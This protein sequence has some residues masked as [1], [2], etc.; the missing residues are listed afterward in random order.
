MRIAVV[1]GGPAGLY[2]AALWKGRHVSDE[3]RL[4]EQNAA[5]ATFGF[6]VVFS[7]RALDF[8]REDDPDT[9][10]LIAP[11]MQHWRDMT[12]THRGQSIVIDGVGFSAI[13]RLELLQ[14]LQQ[15]ARAAGVDCAFAT[16]I[17]PAAQLAGY[18]LI[19]AADGAHS[20][21]RRRYEAY[22][23]TSLSHIGNRFIWYG[24]RKRFPTLTQTFVACEPGTFNAHHYPYS[25]CMSTFIVECDEATWVRAGFDAVGEEQ[26]R[27][28]CE[29]VFS[30][31]LDGHPL[32]SN[33][34]QWREFP[35][36]WN[37]RWSVR[38]MVLIGD[39][40][41]TAHYSIGSGTRLALLDALALV[42]ALE[43][44]PGDLSAALLRFQSTRWAEVERLVAASRRS[45]LWYERFATH[46][47]LAPIDLAMSYMRRSERI[48]DSRLRVTSP[49]FMALHDRAGIARSHGGDDK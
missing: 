8:L 32:V 17:D 11:R 15:R 14:L 45:A 49:R 35:L 36:I 37:A 38:N 29:Q 33:R 46:M 21:L 18:D 7:D 48:D 22:L 3:V 6:G 28:V 1:G 27:R 30:A 2:F 39:S 34:S 44:A 5:D 40:L 47:R 43:N 20:R 23:G 13:G 19:V 25:P 24:T 26:A 31:T 42:K 41:R 10:A 9:A 4:F 16:A 12:I